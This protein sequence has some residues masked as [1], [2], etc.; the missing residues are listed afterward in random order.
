MRLIL[1]L[2]LFSTQAFGQWIANDEIDASKVHKWTP[3]LKD[4]YQGVYHFGDS[5]NE[6]DLLLIITPEKV[7]GQIRSGSW[8]DDGKGWIRTFENLKDIRIEGNRFS[9]NKTSGEFVTFDN[10]K[11]KIKGLKVNNPWSGIPE[12]GQ[13]EIGRKKGAV[14]DFFD[15]K[16]PQAS[17]RILDEN[18]LTSLAEPNLKIMRNEIFARYGF[19]FKNGGDMDNYFKKQDWYHAQ[20][21]N[22]D[23]FL[24]DLE[25]DNLK[26]IQEIEDRLRSKK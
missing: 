1:I 19:K 22:V 20:H 8:S 24:T 5:E 21:D 16:L 25:K 15:G 14:T 13:W 2:T 18:E 17:F 7:I 26:R 23:K 4:E 11:E 9:S 12:P 3:S 6:S 10:G